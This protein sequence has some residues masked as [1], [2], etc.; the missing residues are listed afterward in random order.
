MCFDLDLLSLSFLALFLLYSSISDSFLC[1]T[2]ASVYLYLDL[3]SSI[4]MVWSDSVFSDTFLLGCVTVSGF[5]TF[6]ICCSFRTGW[7]SL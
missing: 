3:I 5:E 1:S 7:A 6:R 2:F 4:L